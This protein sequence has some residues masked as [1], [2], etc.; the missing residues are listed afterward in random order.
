M[1]N[2]VSLEEANARLSRIGKT[3]AD[4]ARDLNVSQHVAAQV[5]AGKLKGTRGDAHKVAVAVGIK[6]GI[7]VSDDMPIAEA[8]RAAA[9]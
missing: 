7:V 3:A 2:I 4:V 9:R 8:M 1:A 6:E 5:L